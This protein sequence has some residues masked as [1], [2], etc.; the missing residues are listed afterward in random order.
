MSEKTVLTTSEI[1]GF[2]M[3]EGV[4]RPTIVLLKDG[5]LQVTTHYSREYRSENAGLII[6]LLFLR[7]GGT[8]VGFQILNLRNWW[9]DHGFKSG[10]FKI[11][12]ILKEIREYDCT[13]T[14]RRAIDEIALPMME[15]M[16]LED[17]ISV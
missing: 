2:Y 7:S 4:A 17:E 10:R 12:D 16:R 5:T 1:P 8:C 11:S 13:E 3:E 15:A 9:K 14:G 6:E